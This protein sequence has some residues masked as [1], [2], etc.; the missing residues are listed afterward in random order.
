MNRNAPVIAPASG[1]SGAPDQVR[2]LSC[3]YDLSGLPESG[4][5]PECG[6]PI[7]RSLRGNLL[8]FASPTYLL[9]LRTGA[10]LALVATIL[11]VFGWIPNLALGALFLWLGIGS[12]EALN[13]LISVG[14]LGAMLF[15]WWM[16]STPDPAFVGLDDSRDWRVRLRWLLPF[17]ASIILCNA[18]VQFAF[19]ASLGTPV[20]VG[21]GF[22]LSYAEMLSWLSQILHAMVVYAGLKYVSA[23]SL[24]VPSNKL[25]K[26]AMDAA[27][28]IGI[29]IVLL[30]L[31]VAFGIGGRIVGF[32]H[33]VTII[34][35]LSAV[36]V[37]LLW[38]FHYF[39]VLGRLRAELS[40]TLVVAR[41]I[42]R[43]DHVSAESARTDSIQPPPMTQS[44]SEAS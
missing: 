22:F 4:V 28:M 11:Y 15:G 8:R 3:G 42:Q 33:V 30:V 12:S 17:A 40:R 43:A 34:I 25:R 35:G 10:T 21:A 36:I 9:T 29:L 44:G 13:A 14:A 7:E 38:I 6:S 2:C 5:C 19:S 23:L 39:A 18:V 27:T 32:L 24:R 41:A 20:A 31:M 1:T 16:L 37:L 26:G